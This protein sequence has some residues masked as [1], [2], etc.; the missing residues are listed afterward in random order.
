[1]EEI[2]D[3]F[4]VIGKKKNLRRACQMWCWLPEGSLLRRK[5]SQR[6]LEP[7]NDLDDNKCDDDDDG[8]DDDDDDDDVDDDAD[9]DDDNDD[10]DDVENLSLRRWPRPITL[11]YLGPPRLLGLDCNAS[12]TLTDDQ[13]CTS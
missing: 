10:D 2:K 12:M 11:A 3:I 5:L 9:Y 7:A 6:Q 1:M 8:D 13:W 4:K